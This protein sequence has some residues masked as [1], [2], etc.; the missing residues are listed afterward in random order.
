MMGTEITLSPGTVVSKLALTWTQT[1]G[2]TLMTVIVMETAGTIFG[3]IN[4]PVAIESS[5]N[6]FTYFAGV[7]SF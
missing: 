3:V 2:Q 6:I 5:V 7:C 4:F 1:V